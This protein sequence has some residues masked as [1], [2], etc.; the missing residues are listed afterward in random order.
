MLLDYLLLNYC[1]TDVRPKPFNVRSSVAA[2]GALRTWT[3][4]GGTGIAANIFVTWVV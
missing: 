1:N 4:G 3:F 2:S